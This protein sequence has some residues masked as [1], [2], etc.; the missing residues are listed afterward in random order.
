VTYS[1]K[2]DGTGM[3]GTILRSVRVGG[4]GNITGIISSD[5]DVALKCQI[6]ITPVEVGKRQDIRID[7]SSIGISCRKD[8]EASVRVAL[9][10]D[11]GDQ[12]WIS[13][14]S[15]TEQKQTNI[16]AIS[17]AVNQLRRQ[18]SDLSAQFVQ[19]GQQNDTN[20]SHLTNSAATLSGKIDN[21][22]NAI[23]FGGSYSQTDGPWQATSTNQYTNPLT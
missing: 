10:T 18:L 23:H 9:T 14:P 16:D 22:S 8:P 21:V 17:D 2:P 15:V 11:Q 5:P 3:T 7:R 6:G 1:P 20:I 13:L 12:D 4:F 19:Y